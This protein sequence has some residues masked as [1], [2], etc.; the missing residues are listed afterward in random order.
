MIINR[1]QAISILE[2]KGCLVY[3]DDCN[4]RLADMINEPIKKA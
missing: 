1:K 3:A 4:Q 2:S